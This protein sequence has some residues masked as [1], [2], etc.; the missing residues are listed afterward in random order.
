MQD[1]IDI[2]VLQTLGMATGTRSDA[3]MASEGHRATMKKRLLG[4]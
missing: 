1:T 4:P 2:K 3:R